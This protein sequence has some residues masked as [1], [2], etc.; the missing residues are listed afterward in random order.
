MPTMLDRLG[1]LQRLKA[2]LADNSAELEHLEVSRA[3]LEQMVALADAAAGQQAV[4]TGA[5]QEASQQLLAAVTEG[6]R[7]ATIL[8]LA[9]KQHYGISAE[10]LAEFGLQPYRRRPRKRAT[11]PVEDAKPEPTA[12]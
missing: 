10:K 6:E 3:R 2:R 4:H 8:R 11:P 12:S 7:L 1:E 9:V 5:K